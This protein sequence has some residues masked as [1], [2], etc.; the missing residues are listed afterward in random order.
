M[1]T[2]LQGIWQ[3]LRR[4]WNRAIVS[5]TPSPRL[6]NYARQK[7]VESGDFGYWYSFG[8]QAWAYSRLE[9][10]PEDRRG[11]LEQVYRRSKSDG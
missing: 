8:W 3:R 9:Y 2:G 11:W 6:L 1:K 4:G 5:L 7:N 10:N